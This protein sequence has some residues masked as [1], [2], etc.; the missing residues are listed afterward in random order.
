MD[1]LETGLRL[2]VI[3]QQLLIAV[4]LLAG[5]GSPAIRRSCA[6]FVV[7][8]A[9]YLFMSSVTLRATAPWVETIALPL[10]LFVA[11][12]LWLFAQ[13]IF[14]APWPR[15]AVMALV[16][17]SGIAAWI[18]YGGPE[19]VTGTTQQ[20]IG[21]AHRIVGLMVVGHALWFTLR[22]RIDDLIE[23]RRL[24]RLLF[25]AVIGL[26]V[27]AVLIVEL[28]YGGGAV[29]QVLDFA[30]VCA[31]AALTLGFAV[32]LLRLDTDLIAPETTA[33][34]AIE[35]E[36]LTPVA[37]VGLER[38]RRRMETN[39]AWKQS[40][41][42]IVQLARQL[43]LPEHQLRRLINGH[44]GYRNFSAYLN[45]FRIAAARQR[46]A[47]PADA[48]TPVLTIALDVGFASLGPFN[49]AFRSITGRTPSEYRRDALGAAGPENG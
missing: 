44:L 34:A 43:D 8:A 15:K 24:F 30:N 35:P 19:S 1:D 10:S 45:G 22:D 38:L 36:T 25:V 3:G 9:A 23:R 48:R 12:A 47:D 6:L 40:G 2:L 46:L 17:L 39:E 28:L 14:E 26:Q 20:L 42:T 13:G 37:R 49:R 41:L 32:P 27:A 5:T 31:I 21:A 7:C 11:Y 33:A 4:V 16:F 29:P 18:A